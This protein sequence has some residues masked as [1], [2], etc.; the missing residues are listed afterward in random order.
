MRPRPPLRWS[1]YLLGKRMRTRMVEPHRGENEMRGVAILVVI[2][3]IGFT[4]V[5]GAR[6]STTRAYVRKDG[7][8]VAPS[9][10]TT[11][12]RTKLDNYSSKPN[13]N[14]YTGKAGTVDPYK[15]PPPRK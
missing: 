8:Y 12:N 15:L 9:I 6:S 2:A 7:V 1:L 13:V 4:T 14:P 10:R 3:S 11:P 5:A